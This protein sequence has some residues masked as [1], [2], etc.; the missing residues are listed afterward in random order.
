[1]LLINF[2]ILNQ[3][4][5]I[6]NQK[7]KFDFL[8]KSLEAATAI[9]LR[10]TLSIPGIDTMIVGTTRPQRWQENAKYVSE[11]NLSVEEFEAIRDRWREGDGENWPQ[12]T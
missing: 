3:K 9:A 8:K 12:M 7:L 1:M 11:G 4:L 6:F 2:H 5:H 10:F